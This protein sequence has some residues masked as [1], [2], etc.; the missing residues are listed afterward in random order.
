[1]WACCLDNLENYFSTLNLLWSGF[2]AAEGLWFTGFF[3]R[4]FTRMRR[5]GREIDYFFI[6]WVSSF[7]RMPCGSDQILFLEIAQSTNGLHMAIDKDDIGRAIVAEGDL[8]LIAQEA[9]RFNKSFL[10]PTGNPHKT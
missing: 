9:V 1:M 10:W 3:V 8:R 2:C 4:S 5:H 7:L 6:N